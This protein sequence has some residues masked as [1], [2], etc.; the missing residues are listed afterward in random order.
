MLPPLHHLMLAALPEQLL[1]SRNSCRPA[2]APSQMLLL[3]GPSWSRRPA[4]GS[5]GGR[6]AGREAWR[7]HTRGLVAV[8][9]TQGAGRYVLGPRLRT[10]KVPALV[11]RHTIFRLLIAWQ[12][13]LPHNLARPTL[14]LT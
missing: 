10:I 9:G 13:G 1:R 14:M 3:G 8:D 7:G 5:D 2:A 11:W 12:P 6:G 4:A